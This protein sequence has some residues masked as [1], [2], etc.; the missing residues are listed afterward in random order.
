MQGLNT[1]FLFEEKLLTMAKGIFPERT[2]RYLPLPRIAEVCKSPLIF[3]N[4]IY[5]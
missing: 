4:Y 5:L 2:L 1:T 3:L